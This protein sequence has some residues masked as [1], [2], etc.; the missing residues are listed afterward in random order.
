MFAA[1][2]QLHGIP[3]PQSA[4]TVPPL[5]GPQGLVN[6]SPSSLRA[7]MAVRRL[8]TVA[9]STPSYTGINHYWTYE[10]D[11]IPGI[12]K[13]MANVGP[14]GNLIIQV[15][16]MA[17]PHKGVEL[18]FRRTYNSLSRH[19]YVG[20]DGS[21]IS[22]YGAGWT[23]TF[24]AHVAWNSGN[25]YGQGISIYDID[26][27]RYD[28]LSDGQGHWVPP[29]GQ[30]AIL[31]FDGSGGY[32][33]TKKSGSVYHFWSPG[34]SFTGLAGR[35]IAIYGRN[36]NTNLTFNYSFQN[37][38][39]SC[40]CNLT[41]ISVVEED[42]RS[43][44]LQF[45][46][47][48][49]G[50]Q[51]QRLL[52][53]LIWPNGTTVSYGYDTNGNLAEVDKPPNSTYTTQC[54]GGVSQCLPE[55][56][57]YSI[58][59]LI[60][61]AAGPRY[62]LGPMRG[63]A[64]WTGTTSYGGY[65]VFA[66]GVGGVLSG[67]I[68][69][70]YMNPTPNDGTSTPIQAGILNGTSYRSV[71]F[72]SR[73]S[74][75]V[76]WSDSDGH[77][78]IYTF[79]TI[80]RVTQSQ[81]WSGSTYLTTTQGWDAQNNPISSTDARGNET[82]YAYDSNGNAI[83]SAS[84]AVTL[85]NGTFRATSLYS[86]DQNNN[87]TAFCGPTYTHSLG[88]DWNT[89][90]QA[91]DSLCPSNAGARLLSWTYP[92]YEPFGELQVTTSPM[93]YHHYLFYNTGAQQGSDFG[94]VT[95]VM[96]DSISQ[97]DGTSRTPSESQIYDQFGNMTCR[98]VLND[99][100]NPNN[101]WS[102]ASYDSVGRVLAASDADDASQQL[103]G[104]TGGL[105]GSQI[106]TTTAYY[107]NGAAASSQT[108]AERGS[109]VSTSFAYDANN[110]EI[111]DT[112][113]FS[114]MP[115]TTTKY[116]DG[117]DRL[118]EVVQP[119]DAADYVSYNWMTR[120]K[121][122]LSMGS[123]VNV[124]GTPSFAAHGNLFAT[125][126]FFAGQWIDAKGQ[127]FDALDRP[128]TK[129][130]YYPLG[131]GQ[132]RALSN[133]YDQTSGTLGHVS[134]TVSPINDAATYK[135]DAAGETTDVTY[136]GPDQTPS[137]HFL[138]D[139]QGRIYQSTSSS[140][141]TTSYIYN[142]DGFLSSKIEGAGGA[143]SA[144]A[145]LNYA[146]YP[147]GTRSALSVAPAPG[148]GGWSQ[149]NLFSYSYRSDGRL[150]T[151]AVNYPG[152]SGSFSNT[153]T[154]A[155]RSLSVS[156]PYRNPTTT[157]TYNGFGA[158]ASASLRNGSY[159]SYSYDAEGEVTGFQAPTSGGAT[160]FAYTYNVRGENVSRNPYMPGVASWQVQLP[161]PNSIPALGA[162]IQAPASPAPGGTP[163]PIGTIA[164]DA[165]NAV[166]TDVL[167]T[168]SDG[169]QT[170][171]V[172]STSDSAGRRSSSSSG[173]TQVT[174]PDGSVTCSM[175]S[176]GTS[177]NGFDA[178]DHLATIT[179]SGSSTRGG[180]R[181]NEDGYYCGTT[182][183]SSATSSTYA[184]GGDGHPAVI[185]KVNCTGCSP[186]VS[187]LH[188][189]GD[190]LLFVSMGG[191]VWDIKIGTLGDVTP[192]DPNSPGITVSDRNPVSGALDSVHNANT[193]A[194]LSSTFL[195]DPSASNCRPY[196]SATGWIA[197]WMPRTDGICDG[198]TLIQG[199]RAVDPATGDWMTPDRFAGDVNDPM[200]QR[201]FAYNR[202]N[203]LSYS[204][205]SG[206]VPMMTANAEQAWGTLS[207]G[208]LTGFDTSSLGGLMVAVSGEDS[209][210]SGV[211]SEV[212][213]NSSPLAPKA[214]SENF[215]FSMLVND[216]RDVTATTYDGTYNS[217]GGPRGLHP[218][219]NESRD[220]AA[221]VL[222][223]RGYI[224]VITPGIAEVWGYGNHGY[225]LSIEFN[226][227]G[228]YSHVYIS[229]WRKQEYDTAYRWIGG[230]I[231]GLVQYR[232]HQ[233]PEGWWIAVRGQ[234]DA[235]QQRLGAQ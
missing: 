24:D 150:T 140:L 71:Y 235:H 100:N 202:G 102:A 14:G 184:W 50:G 45:N 114:N 74:T 233:M 68:D 112:H 210:P 168:T 194:G 30:F 107:Q 188:W 66:F 139:A 133:Y 84:P 40:S 121:Y 180:L 65:V 38:D 64:D 231:S 86:Y 148:Y 16:D 227:E 209:S 59:S 207:S 228:A 116:Y 141:G 206:F 204:D 213:A 119:H 159:N 17:I 177:T 41:V 122:D 21:Q 183:S 95:S 160:T 191:T 137:K 28:Y 60:S 22:N 47:F 170:S 69:T 37:G 157:I 161:L 72:T 43:A 171:E 70:G 67:A 3:A 190:Q 158:I 179:T 57:G 7:P 127:S 138:Y 195:G 125:Q 124:G 101:G 214:N 6:S 215:D 219:P 97:N 156:D 193:G 89:R 181:V 91:S 33:W 182:T 226:A 173:A 90:P 4:A 108:T 176:A 34:A 79:D 88:L 117:A 221:K 83:A 103:C 144:P 20:T 145:T 49:V 229:G 134:S 39:A 63:V 42:G 222:K 27:A 111:G 128:A 178:E 146:Y 149:S 118:V 232:E 92:A 189:D 110:N 234:T 192:Q 10:E 36:N 172:T 18:A 85:A 132:P 126:T 218:I 136:T 52:A 198:Q 109:G 152:A 31:T 224:V 225:N 5:R 19:D 25:Q 205:P 153:Y 78:T 167:W 93:G 169:T 56:Y 13:Y 81:S 77:Q 115:A 162:V 48:S 217:A 174:S 62:V 96:G 61:W 1:F 135:Y 53:K 76:M 51:P 73:A 55:L 197:I 211:A 2:R 175:G 220:I 32:F 80:G 151:L 199:V 15:N 29:P 147:D 23:N 186:S 120:Y 44:Q 123:T 113:H 163:M 143:F 187:Q 216:A 54:Q 82:D 201:S 129:Y 94:L 8:T 142:A 196:P 130:E 165:A 46:D 11:A 164:L 75:G 212:A 26:G 166:A 223:D 35:M 230:P 185:T 154:P 104:R 9:L 106:V 12:G 98:K 200:S 58:A 155:G 99:P 208:A 87:V 203:G 105:P 131:S